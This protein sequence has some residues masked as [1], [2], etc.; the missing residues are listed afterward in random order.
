MD[1]KPIVLVRQNLN[2]GQKFLEYLRNYFDLNRPGLEYDHKLVTPAYI[3]GN[4]MIDGEKIKFDDKPG[5]VYFTDEQEK[6]TKAYEAIRAGR[7][8]ATKTFQSGE[9]DLPK[10]EEA[11]RLYVTA[12]AEIA[13]LREQRD[14]AARGILE[15]FVALDG[16]R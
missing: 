16:R 9:I 2:F 8:V 12:T 10:V 11:A 6:I 13:K 1:Q 7:W 3:L 5:R 14:G 15:R 4:F